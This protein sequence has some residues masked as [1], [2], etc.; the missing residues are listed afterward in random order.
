MAYN[1]FVNEDARDSYFDF[2]EPIILDLWV[3]RVRELGDDNVL[4]AAAWNNSG[5]TSGRTLVGRASWKG[6]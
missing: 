2:E 6:K 4:T 1:P 5:K 3:E